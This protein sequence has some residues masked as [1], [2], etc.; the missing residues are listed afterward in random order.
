MSLLLEKS[1]QFIDK[2]INAKSNEIPAD[3]LEFWLIENGDLQADNDDQWTVFMAAFVKMK[4]IS[5]KEY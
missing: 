5:K 4:S 2:N 1:F 3:L